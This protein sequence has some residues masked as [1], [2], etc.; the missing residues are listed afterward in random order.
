MASISGETVAYF[1]T[2]KSS[3]ALHALS[4][5]NR[6]PGRGRRYRTAFFQQ[7]QLFRNWYKPHHHLLLQTRKRH[8]PA[9]V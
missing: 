8:T 2:K 4:P 6:T 9:R 5:D 3:Y 7:A 1:V